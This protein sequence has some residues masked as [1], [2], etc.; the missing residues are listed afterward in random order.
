MVTEDHGPSQHLGGKAHVLEWYSRKQKRVTR[1]TYSAE[2]NALTDSIELGKIVQ[3]AY[4][5]LVLKPRPTPK[6]LLQLCDE[7]KLPVPLEA[8][9][10]AKSVFDSLVA[11]ET[12]MPTESSLILVLLQLKEMLVLGVLR[13]LYWIATED[14]GADGLN[15]GAVSRAATINI[16]TKGFWAPEKA[17]E[18]H[19][20][21]RK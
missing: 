15:K 4:C 18:R 19:S 3:Y 16:P 5:E 9:I 13:A 1:S 8:C 11:E 2:L 7:G 21:R 10:D 20:E 6:E 17:Y 14:M 12:R